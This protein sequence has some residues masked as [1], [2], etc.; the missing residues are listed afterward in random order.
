MKCFFK[1]NKYTCGGGVEIKRKY[2]I[3]CWNK[4]NLSVEKY[5]LEPIWGKR[6][7]IV[8]TF[9]KGTGIEIGASCYP[10]PILKNNISIK[11]V[12]YR[13]RNEVH[14]S[15]W[16]E[17]LNYVH[18][19][20]VDD[21]ERLDEIRDRSLDFIIVCHL[22]EHTKNPIGAIQIWLKKLKRKGKLVIAVPD[23]STIFDHDRQLTSF[24]HLLLD[25][26]EPSNTRDYEH[27][28]EYVELS[29]KCKDHIEQEVKKL[30]EEDIRIHYHCWDFDTFFDFLIK[31]NAY[32]KKSFEL[33]SYNYNLLIEGKSGKEM[34][35]VLEKR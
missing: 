29:W 27:Y 21:A 5:R 15:T 11:Y 20:I 1:M 24:E 19:D 33:I 23:M 26:E 18:V 10:V 34:I 3:S 25:N 9:C 14:D 6:S 31:L 35:A 17:G 8:E 32:N 12:D 30:I 4:L 22:L 13:D 28:L 2:V 16:R 7:K